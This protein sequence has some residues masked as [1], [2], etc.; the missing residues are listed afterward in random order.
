MGFTG[1]SWVLLGFTGFYWVSLGF[2]GFYWVL[3]S[4]LLGL[5]VWL[6]LRS[7]KFADL[8]RYW[9]LLGW[10]G[11]PRSVQEREPHENDSAAAAVR[12]PIRIPSGGSLP[13]FTD[14]L[15][16]VS[17]F[18]LSSRRDFRAVLRWIGVDESPPTKRASSPRQ[19]PTTDG[20]WVISSGRTRPFP[21]SPLIEKERAVYVKGSQ[22][23]WLI[24]RLI[25]L[26]GSINGRF[27]HQRGLT[28][29][30]RSISSF[31]G[32]SKNNSIVTYQILVSSRMRLLW[33]H[34]SWAMK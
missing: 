22:R 34:R 27:I 14:P 23:R 24:G 13:S 3:L 33:T 17:R 11:L 29:S 20:G 19:H 16:N 5:E 15:R 2:T 6:T 4:L 31:G 8:D 25:R 28:D 30:R 10:G 12:N 1:V 7:F 21:P 9:V 18:F 32:T 26:V